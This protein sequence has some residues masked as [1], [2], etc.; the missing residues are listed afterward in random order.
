MTVPRKPPTSSRR[1]FLTGQAAVDAL[2]DVVD[3]TSQPG[4]SND[5]P[6]SPRSYLFQIG[7]SAMACEFQVFLNAGQHPAGPDAALR[8]LDLVDALEDQMSVYRPH[9]EISEINRRAAASPVAVEPRLFALLQQAQKLFDETGGAFDITSGPLSKVWGFYR[10]SGQMPSDDEIRAA[11]EFVG[12]QQVE[13]NPERSTIH[14]L[15][16]GLE[17]NLNAIGQ[18]HALDRCAELLLAESVNNFLM[19]G[20]QSSILA[21]GSRAGLA[22]SESGWSVALRH[23]LRPELRLAEIWLRDR[24]LGTSGSGT[25]FFYHAGRRFGH[26]LDPRTGRPAEA[27]LSSTVLA[28]TAAEADALATA[29]YVLGLEESR[30]YCARHPEIAAL[31][32]TPG[33]RSGAAEV[34]A[35][36]L[37]EHD[38]KQTAE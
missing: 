29:F 3:R 10:R 11:L 30:A 35:L 24:A 23:P 1:K 12:G 21:R 4:E 38:W 26:I 34:H 28:P 13:M 33:E 22:A 17:I 6:G 27:V 7:R 15:R 36:G 25:Q 2:V 31:I 16:P 18:G 8:A 5:A 37:D 14:F 32:V 9:T 20:G 19:H